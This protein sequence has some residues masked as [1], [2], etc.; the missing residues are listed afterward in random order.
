[1]EQKQVIS[2]SRRKQK[3]NVEVQGG[4]NLIKAPVKKILVFDCKPSMSQSYDM[5]AE[6]TD[7][8]LGSWGT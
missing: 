5:N 3:S 7:A 8:L 2:S 4:S 1:M 6:K